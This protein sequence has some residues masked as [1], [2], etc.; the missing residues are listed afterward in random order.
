MVV[1]SPQNNSPFSSGRLLDEDRITKALNLASSLGA[2]YS[3]IRLVSETTNTASL[4]DG[5]LERAIPGQE[6]GVTMRILADG[7]W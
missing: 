7:A 6:V 1:T 5:K 3:E 4:K 2:T